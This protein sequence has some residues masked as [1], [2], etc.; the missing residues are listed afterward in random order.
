M[1]TP[2][3]MPRLGD[4]M[5]EGIVNAWKKASGEAVRQGEVIAE[6]ESEKL[7]YE[8]QAAS[9][10]VLHVVVKEGDTAPVDGVIAYLLAEGEAPPS[11]STPR[12]APGAP[13]T[14]PSA[15]SRPAAARASGDVVLS[16]PGARRLAANLGVDIS[17][18]TPTGPRG[19][20]V[21]DDVRDY[22][23]RQRQAPARPQT[24]EAPPGY[25]TPSKVVP[26]SGIRRAI[27]S[28][29]KGSISSTAQLSFFL[30]A[31]VTEAQRL[32]REAS[33]EKGV[34]IG[35]PHVLIK[36][37]AEALKRHPALNTV[38]H[39]GS[40]LYFDEINIGVAVA[41]GEG[42]IVPVV[43]NAGEMDIAQLAA[44]ADDFAA[45]ARDGKLSPGDT[46]GGTFTISV[47][48]SVDGFTPILSAGQSALLGAGRS[49]QKPV[50]QDS[51]IVVREMMTLS[52]TVDH[53]VIDGAVAASFIRRLQQLIER[54][55][56][57][58][59]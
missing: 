27:A 41:L 10:G 37:C 25:P 47:L 55:A 44:S 42:L 32:R 4:F 26:L 24:S 58:F 50:V 20:V 28:H 46:L 57:L 40:I 15:P 17:Q 52:L 3:V 18:V 51:E 45:R 34:T 5:T 7:N 36:A 48:G 8:L 35:L 1:A 23:E 21:E 12:L 54:P 53:Q 2:I 13:A 30:E 11:P 38:L 49:L 6:I 31:D 19:R 56:Q 9:S 59:R 22:A 16:T 43:R 29:M 39:D 33:R 14:Q